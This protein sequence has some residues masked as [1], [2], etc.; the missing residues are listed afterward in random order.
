MYNCTW[1]EPTE[2]PIQTRYLGH[3][4]GYQPVKDQDSVVGKQQKSDDDLNQAKP[5]SVSLK[6]YFSNLHYNSTS[7]SFSDESLSFWSLSPIRKDMINILNIE[8][9]KKCDKMFISS[10]KMIKLSLS[11][12]LLFFFYFFRLKMLGFLL[13]FSLFFPFLSS[14]LSRVLFFKSDPA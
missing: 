8:R 6:H 3:V 10:S 14:D 1:N 4:T 5:L 11:L 7:R 2:Q 12:P 13:T 9:N